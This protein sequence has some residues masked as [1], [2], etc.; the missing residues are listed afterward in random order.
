VTATTE[1][2][3]AKPLSRNAVIADARFV[4]IASQNA[5]EIHSVVSVTTT[6]S[7]IPAFVSLPSRNDTHFQAAVFGSPADQ[8]SKPLPCIMTG[9]SKPT[10]VFCLLFLAA[11]CMA[12]QK[13]NTPEF[14]NTE[15][16]QLVVTRSL[17]NSQG[18]FPPTSLWVCC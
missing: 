7:P 16:I 8:A 18:T 10:M 2:R 12:Q 9:M 13:E 15:E 6:M 17:P 3:A 1:C 14:P 11:F 4:L 5:A